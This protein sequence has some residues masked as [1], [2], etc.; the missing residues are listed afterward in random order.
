MQLFQ[1]YNNDNDVSTDLSGE[2]Q[3][4]MIYHV[5][6]DELSD[7]TIPETA[8]VLVEEYDVLSNETPIQTY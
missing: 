6:M 5:T 1:K 4:N 8:I 7:I 3:P 2:P